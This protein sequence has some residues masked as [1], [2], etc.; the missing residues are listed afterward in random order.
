MCQDARGVRLEVAAAL[1]DADATAAS[2]QANDYLVWAPAPVAAD[3]GESGGA[4]INTY[5]YDDEQDGVDGGLHKARP[6]GG[7][8]NLSLDR[9]ELLL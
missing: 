8:G 5:R 4:L 1:Q 2:R 6:A 9:I 3:D 7:E